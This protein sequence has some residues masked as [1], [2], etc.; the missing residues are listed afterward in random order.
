LPDTARRLYL[1]TFSFA[2]SRSSRPGKKLECRRCY[3]FGATVVGCVLERNPAQRPTLFDTE[4]RGN[5]CTSGGGVSVHVK[6]KIPREL[7]EKALVDLKRPHRFACERVGFFSTRCSRGPSITIVHC[8]DYHSL[9]DDHYIEDNFVGVRIGSSAITE[10]MSRCASNKVGQLH[11][12][13][14][15]GHGVPRPSHD[16]CRE[17]PLLA[18]SLR[19]V[20]A[21]QAQGWAIL[22]ADNTI[23]FINEPGQ[24]EDSPNMPL[25]L[26]GYPLTI[27]ERADRRENI[28]YSVLH[29]LASGKSN[30]YTRQSFLGP[31]SERIF[32]NA[33]V[34]IVGL[35]GG[36]SHISQQ[37]AHLGIVNYVLCDAD[38]IT[39]TNL[40]RTVNATLFDVIFKRYKTDIAA[41]T[42]RRLHWNASI[43]NHHAPWESATDS[44]MQCD[45]VVGCV[46]TF[47]GRRDLEA[48]CRRHLIPYVDVGMDVQDLGDR[49][50]IM[51]QVIL[52]MPGRPC[53]RCMGFL[54]D[55]VLAEEARRYGDAGGRP[56]VV[57][58]NGV[59]CSAA[60]G[61]IVDLLTGWSKSKRDSIYLNFRGSD[62]SI[63]D[64]PRL[65]YIENGDCLHYPLLQA[66]DP[67]F[68]TL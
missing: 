44:L 2:K 28:P 29:R 49:R 13:Y 46:D 55:Q 63:T 16:D 48:F 57:W 60:V 65:P 40:N 54:N 14:H 32:S 42:I 9:S 66:G 30:R 62:L 11:V 4:A 59:L 58:S 25:S 12:H 38:R 24:S 41:R 50:E 53:M 26:I 43:I 5:S 68:T 61:V 23:L 64:D 3:D 47:S 51:G 18:R 22:S 17:L 34:G 52:S 45:I 37:L 8:I 15:G 1:A 7:F 20:D 21:E 56:Q 27:Q 10:A 31:D 35:G 36:G 33:I 39:F 67:I 6:L 19:H